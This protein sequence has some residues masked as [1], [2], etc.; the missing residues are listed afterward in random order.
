MAK[1]P[2][3]L[4]LSNGEWL[5][6][7]EGGNIHQNHIHLSEDGEVVLNIKRNGVS[8]YS[9]SGTRKSLSDLWED[10]T[11]EPNKFPDGWRPSI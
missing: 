2:E 7:I 8:D 9:V 11:G 4:Q 5:V 6:H 3:E 10:I 1:H